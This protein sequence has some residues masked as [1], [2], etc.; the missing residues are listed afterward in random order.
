MDSSY[1]CS[2]AG[3]CWRV[4]G[5]PPRCVVGLGAGLGADSPR[6]DGVVDTMLRVCGP[7]WRKQVRKDTCSN[8][9]WTAA[10]SPR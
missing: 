4:I 3:A 8:N 9:V 7:R 5:Y 2:T 6:T 10:T 1:E